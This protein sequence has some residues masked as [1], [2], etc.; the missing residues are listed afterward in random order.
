MK[1]IKCALFFL[2]AIVSLIFTTS[3]KNYEE[4]FT[5]YSANDCIDKNQDDVYTDFRAAGFT[6]IETKELNDIEI[7]ETSKMDIVYSVSINGI[8]DFDG[9]TSFP[10]NAKVVIEYHSAKKEKF[11]FTEEVV[12]NADPKELETLLKEANFIN[13]VT[14]EIFDIDPDTEDIEFKNSIS[15]NGYTQDAF[16]E[17]FP[18]DAQIEIVTH[19][20]Y[21]KYSL[22]VVIDF[23]SNLIFSKYDVVVDFVDFY[24]ESH[25][26]SHGYDKTFEF[27]AQ[28]GEYEIKFTSAENE[29]ISK[30]VKF[31]VTGDTEISYKISCHSDEIKVQKVYQENYNEIGTDEAMVPLSYDDY[32]L[33]NYNTIK[34]QFEKAGFTNISTKAVYDIFFGITDEGEIDEVKIKGYPEFQR[35]DIIPKNT[36]IEISYHMKEEDD[37]NKKKKDTPQ[38]STD[39][40][41][42]E[43]KTNATS[44]NKKSKITID[45]NNDFA[46][47]MKITNQTD[48]ATIKNFVNA[49]IGNVVEFDGCIALMMNHEKYE[50]RF[51][52]LIAGGDYYADK[53]YGPFFSFIDVNYYDMNVTG[54]DIVAEKMNF[55][56]IGKIVE[57]NEDG[58]FI[59]LEPISLQIR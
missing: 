48:A 46:N 24:G 50:T 55:R 22:N 45:N 39:S 10:N 49:N 25:T 15:V 19:K 14:S 58:N 44:E 53:V 17:G 36:S 33:E 8:S 31:K 38:S 21:K 30:S 7:H 11:P 4:V 9:N 18:L 2:F 5:P 29:N 35:G 41:T 3:C 40:K 32:S 59:T 42:T 56:V 23:V 37:P 57:F 26:L 12:A 20:P 1:N 51:D 47:L 43:T 52:V 13:V 27:R 34:K 6:N 16:S 28:E 54:S